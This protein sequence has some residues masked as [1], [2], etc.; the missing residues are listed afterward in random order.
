MLNHLAE[1]V[2][3]FDCVVSTYL[4]DAFDCIFLSC[5]TYAFQSESTVY[6]CL[7]VKELLGWKRCDVWS[8][9][10]CNGSRTQN[11]HLFPKRTLNHLAKLAKWLS[12]TVYLR[13]L[14]IGCEC[15]SV[16]CISGNSRVW[17]HSEM[18][19]WHDKRHTVELTVQI[20][21]HNTAQSFG[22]LAVWMC[23]HLQTKWL[24]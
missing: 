9:S 8:F 11:H 19:T 6:S 7:N 24:R 13:Q 10:D 16:R 1:L 4:Y 17:I 12:C 5:L 22:L 14:Y 21:T 2:K 20:S 23:I 15:L 3:W 18:R